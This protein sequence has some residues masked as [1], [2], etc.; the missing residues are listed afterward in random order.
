MND[1]VGSALVCIVAAGVGGYWWGWQAAY[2]RGW[3]DCEE[4]AARCLARLGRGDE[5]EEGQG[6]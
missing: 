4:W 3:R 1:V 5:D 6:D 2:A